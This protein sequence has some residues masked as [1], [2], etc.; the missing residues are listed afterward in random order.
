MKTLKGFYKAYADWLDKGA[1][2]Y[3]PFSRGLG[4]CSNLQYYTGVENIFVLTR[5]ERQLSD[6]FEDAGL[7]A[8]YPFGEEAFDSYL[9]EN[10]MHLDPNRIAWV[11]NQ[12]TKG[13]NQ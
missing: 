11:K 1:P 6:Q 12:L 7:S 10:N 4:L 9:D 3:R 8:A 2:P 13:E 5:L